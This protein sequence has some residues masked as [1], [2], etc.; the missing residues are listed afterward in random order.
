MESFGC[1]QPPEE[2]RKFGLTS[3][4]LKRFWRHVLNQA[5]SVMPSKRLSLHLS[6]T[7]A[8]DSSNKHHQVIKRRD[9]LSGQNGF[10]LDLIDA[11]FRSATCFGTSFSTSGLSRA[12]H[13]KPFLLEI[14][15]CELQRVLVNYARQMNVCGRG[16]MC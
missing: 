12:F 13:F 16:R 3:N 9:A 6:L 5:Y 8:C 4:L 7:S 14:E 15:L 10:P 11:V 2:S 1:F